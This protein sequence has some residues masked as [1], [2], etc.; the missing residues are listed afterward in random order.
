MLVGHSIRKGNRFDDSVSKYLK[1]SLLR[2]LFVYE[3]IDYSDQIT[4][5][6]LLGHTSGVADYFEDPIQGQ[7]K[8]L[9]VMKKIQTNVD[10]G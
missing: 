1:T 3:G 8:F 6:M 9:D 4:V 7:E 2:D 10:A 5:R